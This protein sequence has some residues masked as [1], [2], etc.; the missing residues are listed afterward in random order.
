L[1]DFYVQNMQVKQESI[2]VLIF[3]FPCLTI[4]YAKKNHIIRQIGRYDLIADLH[5][6]LMQHLSLF[7]D[8]PL[9]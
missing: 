7:I 4:H 8:R 6:P 2:F 5:H 9:A 1:A 3:V